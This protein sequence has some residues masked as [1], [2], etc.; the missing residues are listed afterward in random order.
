MT[1]DADRYQAFYTEKLW[2]LLPAIYRAEDSDDFDVSGPLR[3]LVARVGV[4]AAVVRRSIDR[5]WEDQSIESCEDWVVEYLGDLLATNLVAGLDAAGRR[6]DVG[7]TIYYRRRKGTVALLEELASDITGWTVRVV[8]GFRRLGR[9]RHGLDP[10][11][12]AGGFAD[13]RDAH[14]ASL[15][16]SAFDAHFHAADVRRASRYAISKLAVFAWR[17]HSLDV[18]GVTPVQDK[19]CPNQ[20]TFDPTGRDVQLFAFADTTSGDDWVPPLE[21]QVPGPISA[22]LLAAAYD[23]LYPRSLSVSGVAADFID[24][25]RGRVFAPAAPSEVGYHYGCTSEIGAGPFDRPPSGAAVADDAAL[26]AALGALAPAGTLTL[27]GSRTF[28]KAADVTGIRDVVVRAQSR[29]RPL[30]R[31][32][33]AEW[34]FT[35][36]DDAALRFDGLFLSRADL[37]LRGK[38]DRVTL[39]G[40]TLDPGA[41]DGAGFAAAADGVELKPSRLRIEGTVGV[42]EIERCVLGP[43]EVAAAGEV[44]ALTISDS[45]VQSSDP[46]AACM[47]VS[48]GATE[49]T[50][51]TLIGSAA[52]HRL[53][54][55]GCV[56]SGVVS[57][58]D[59]QHGCVRFSA[60]TAG[61]TLPRKYECVK[62]SPGQPLF[63]SLAFGRH[64]YA[65]LLSTADPALLE[66]G[67][68]GGE[69]GAFAREGNAVKRRGLLVKYQEYMPIGL[70]PVVVEVT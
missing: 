22:G 10:A 53:E 63:A 32:D 46:A 15:T 24:P 20:Y 34:S 36:D 45:I 31:A 4:Q 62:L 30:V 38:L 29:E 33:A 41:W 40:C 69:L 42:L 65:A 57:V 11:I 35:G 19:A 44:E 26:V 18:S 17:A 50:R 51:T 49:L 64:D 59:T 6:A 5:L 70:E 23:E 14:G 68:D 39:R 61:S 55:S 7:K 48:S 13:L 47:T 28:A 56:L 21:H 54:A 67:E 3:E 12:V 37:V 1:L 2:S 16:D 66:G 60:W 43:I 27:G 52:I 25:V 9:T 8:E 58:D